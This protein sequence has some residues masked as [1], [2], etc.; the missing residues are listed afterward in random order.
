MLS[1]SQSHLFSETSRFEKEIQTLKLKIL[2]LESALT[3]SD[4]LRSQKTVFDSDPE[5]TSHLN[6]THLHTDFQSNNTL[7]N[8]YNY[9]GYWWEGGGEGWFHD[10]SGFF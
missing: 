3:V 5:L 10:S 1:K 2:S 9:E 4:K 8:R 6:S 7:L